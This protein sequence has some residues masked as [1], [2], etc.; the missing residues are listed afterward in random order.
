MPLTLV[1]L[2][3]GLLGSILMF[4]GDMLLYFTSGA[5]DMDG[6]LRPYMRIMRDVP[7]GRVRVGGALGPV[8]AF[9]YVPGFAG[10]TLTARGEMDW[11]VWLAAALLALALICGGAYHAQY[12]YLSVIAKAE[13][14][15]LYDEVADNIMFVMR[16]ATVP[17]YLGFVVLGVAIVLGQ[18]VFPT[19]FVVL[20]PLVTSFLG[21][22]WMRVPQPARCA[23]FGGWSNLVFTIMFAAM[24]VCLHSEALAMA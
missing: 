17:M 2:A 18:T 10:L 4:A 12:V 20:T 7:S 9:F 14:E 1:L 8:A 5:Y 22:V 24:L 21:L 23:L 11:L 3:L 19:W 16:F 13:R 15:E 6:T